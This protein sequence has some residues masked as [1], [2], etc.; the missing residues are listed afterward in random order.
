M[1]SNESLHTLLELEEKERDQLLTAFQQA[2]QR[3]RAA[4]GQVEQLI[5]Y[6][7]EYQ[8]RW[9][10]QFSR[11]ASIEILHCY[12]SFS[13]RLGEAIEQQQRIATQAEAHTERARQALTAQEIRVASVRKLIER[14]V[15]EQQRAAERRDQKQTDEAAQRV[16]W[17]AGAATRMASS[18]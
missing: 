14:R 10:G 11:A 7:I 2:Q 1:S 9:T 5:A 8:Q 4:Q 6:R 3:A 15:D 16:A 12:Q 17:Q 13:L 18:A